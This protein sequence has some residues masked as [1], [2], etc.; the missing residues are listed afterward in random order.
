MAN[1]PVAILVIWIGPF[2]SSFDLWLLSIKNSPFDFIF[3][4][5]QKQPIE[6]TQYKWLNS[7]LE[8]LCALFSSTLGFQAALS[9]PY[10]L[11]DYRPLYGE[12]FSDIL[13]NYDYWGYCDLDMVFGDCSSVLELVENKTITKIFQ[14]GH[15]SLIKNDSNINSLYR[16]SNLID[17]KYIYMNEKSCMFDEWHGIGKI[18]KYEGY[19]V[20]HSEIMVDINP[21]SLYFKPSNINSFKHQLFIYNNGSIKHLYYK[22]GSLCKSEFLYIHFQKRKIDFSLVDTGINSYAFMPDKVIPFNE[23]DFSSSDLLKINDRDYVHFINRLFERIKIKIN[24]NL[25]KFDQYVMTIK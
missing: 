23:S 18:L 16:K 5:D 21:N 7:T 22:D 4:T 17:Y 13:Y 11:C 15:L 1:S 24:P 3:V 10:K 20:F 25:N 8:E 12:A 14:R 2:P 6:C 19:E 9:F